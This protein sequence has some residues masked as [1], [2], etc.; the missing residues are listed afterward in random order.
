[1]N[2]FFWTAKMEGKNRD[3][4]TLP[5]SS[6]NNSHQNNKSHQN[7]PTFQSSTSRFT[8][9]KTDLGVDDPDKRMR[10]EAN[11]LWKD[12]IDQQIAEKK[13]REMLE[14]QRDELESR[15]RNV[16]LFR[17]QEY[18][19]QSPLPP[20]LRTTQQEA[21]PVDL[22]PIPDVHSSQ[23][24]YGVTD[25]Q[26]LYSKI[27]RFRTKTNQPKA[28][29]IDPL[30]VMPAKLTVQRSSLQELPKSF[31]KTSANIREK[32]KPKDT[33]PFAKSRNVGPRKVGHQEKEAI[34]QKPKKTVTLPAI[35]PTPFTEP[36][37]T[38]PVL[39]NLPSNHNSMKPAAGIAEPTPL[40]PIE[41]PIPQQQEHRQ[42]NPTVV[43]QTVKPHQV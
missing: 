8:R 27:P 26:L 6:S 13:K 11:R 4:K 12:S 23:D 3:Q 20:H 21:P 30:P 33:I 38:T 29:V 37:N 14:K 34:E 5:P 32:Y 7:N 39:P 9:T 2:D 24:A 28:A 19:S 40:G 10:E 35:L 36:Q 25:Q 22:G 16:K 42:R 18:G 1:M 31:A 41:Q 43:K 15:M 17:Q